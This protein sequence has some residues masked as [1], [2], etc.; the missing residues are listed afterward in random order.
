MLWQLEFVCFLVFF[1]VGNCFSVLKIS[2]GVFSNTSIYGLFHIDVENIPLG[3]KFILYQLHSPFYQLFASTS[4][5]FDYDASIIAYHV[6][7]IGYISNQT[8]ST[9]YVF[10]EYDFPVQVWIKAFAYDAKCKSI[11]EKNIIC[12]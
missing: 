9:F 4:A 11:F 10:S 2:H 12:I 6:G 5:T 7:L 3:S 8:T 1:D